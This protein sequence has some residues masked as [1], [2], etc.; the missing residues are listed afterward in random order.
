MFRSSLVLSITLFTI[1]LRLIKESFSFV[2][3]VEVAV[4]ETFA[5]LK[6][7]FSKSDSSRET[8]IF[9]L[10]VYWPAFS[11]SSTGASYFNTKTAG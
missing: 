1:L 4:T 6:I 11:I 8:G 2:R 10:L 9:E 7:G 5:G 3:S